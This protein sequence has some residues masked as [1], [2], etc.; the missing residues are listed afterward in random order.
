[1]LDRYAAR[2]LVPRVASF[3]DAAD[4]P[5]AWVWLRGF[6]ARPQAEREAG[7][8]RPTLGTVEGGDR[9]AG[10]GGLRLGLLETPVPGTGAG[11]LSL[12]GR[13][14]SVRTA[15]QRALSTAAFSTEGLDGQ[16]PVSGATLSLLLSARC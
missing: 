12:A 3:A 14:L 9:P 10:P 8:W 6:M 15:G 2:A 13:A 7:T 4:S 11:H 5:S 1:M 16:A